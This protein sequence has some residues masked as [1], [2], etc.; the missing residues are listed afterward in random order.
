MPGTGSP[1]SS[2]NFFL[3]YNF[4]FLFNRDFTPWHPVAIRGLWI[5][6]GI[7][8]PE[9]EGDYERSHAQPWDDES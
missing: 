9:E 6:R 8:R 1:N 5:P 2:L 4:N 7:R 3:F